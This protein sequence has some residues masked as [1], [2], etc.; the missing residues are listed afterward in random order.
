MAL[1]EDVSRQ[2]DLDN[3]MSSLRLSSRKDGPCDRAAIHAQRYREFALVTNIFC[4]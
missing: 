4:R 3:V 2:I 1:L